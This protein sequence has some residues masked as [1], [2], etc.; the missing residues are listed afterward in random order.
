MEPFQVVP[1]AEKP[2]FKHLTSTHNFRQFLQIKSLK[3]TIFSCTSSRTHCVSST[4]STFYP[5]SLSPIVLRLLL[6]VCLCIQYILSA[7]HLL[8]TKKENQNDLLRNASSWLNKIVNLELI[9]GAH[10]NSY[11]SIDSTVN[12]KASALI[13]L[14]SS[15]RFY[16]H[17]FLCWAPEPDWTLWPFCQTGSDTELADKIQRLIGVLV[18]CYRLTCKTIRFRCFE[19]MIQSGSTTQTQT[20]SE[21]FSTLKEM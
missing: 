7:A 16:V 6:C 21:T 9:R 11:P 8:K 1:G 3:N 12:T 4:L 10:Q 13:R 5:A 20:R 15:K 18:C 19:Y 17:G 14:P 2:H